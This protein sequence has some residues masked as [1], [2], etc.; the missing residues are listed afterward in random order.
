MKK[1]MIIGRLGAKPELRSTTGGKQVTS[2][3]VAVKEKI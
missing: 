3:S 1:I 2:F